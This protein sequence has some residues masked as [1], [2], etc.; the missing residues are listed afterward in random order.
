MFFS[1]A[2]STAPFLL[3]FSSS[4]ASVWLISQVYMFYFGLSTI[5][6]KNI[7]IF[8]LTNQRNNDIMCS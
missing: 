5:F 7:K 3:F 8:W 4:T 1:F 6:T 2:I